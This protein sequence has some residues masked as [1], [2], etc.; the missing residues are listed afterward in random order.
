M[1]NLAK[2]RKFL[3]TAKAKNQILLF[4][5]N[6]NNKTHKISVAA[7][8]NGTSFKDTEKQLMFAPIV[9]NGGFED[10]SG[11]RL[12]DFGKQHVFALTKKT[13]ELSL[14]LSKDG[15]KIE[16]PV[17]LKNIKGRGM[18][19]PDFLYRDQYVL[20]FNDNGIKVAFSKDLNKWDVK[21][22]P[23]VSQTEGKKEMDINGIINTEEGI[24]LILTVKTMVNKLP[25]YS[26]AAAMF[27]TKNPEKII[28]KIDRFW[29]EPMQW[30]D[31]DIKP[32]GIAYTDIDMI[33]YWYVGKLGL[34]AVNHP[35]FQKEPK[36]TKEQKRISLSILKKHEKN[37]IIKPREDY[38]WESK[39]VFNPAALHANG[40]T[41]LVYRA[42]G[43][44]YISVLGYASSTDG[45]NID[46][47]ADEPVYIP[48][49]PFEGAM[50][51]L[52]TSS[53]YISGLG[54]GG[55][56]DPRLTLI[57]DKVYMTY[58]AFNGWSP[59]RVAMTSIKSKD[60]FDKN[61]AWEKP[62]LISKP[63]VVD[64]NA[65]ILPEK[66]NGKYVIF[67]RVFP[68]ILIDFV[69]DLNFDGTKF[70]K[71]EHV[72][73]PRKNFWD[74]RK[75]GVGPTPLRT[76]L[77]WLVIYHA[78]DNKDDSKYK[79]GAM[80]LDINDPTKVLYRSNSPILEPSEWY[81]NQGHK[82]GVAYP[83]GATIVN[84]NLNVYYGG[85]D[86]V[87][88]VANAKI[89][90]FLDELKKDEPIKLDPVTIS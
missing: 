26:L 52:P 64:K 81:E 43:D 51:N 59:P 30:M 16:K 19:V 71:G 65:A 13:G 87:I 22:F 54:Y 84:D 1:P 85:A 15:T 10:L 27:D 40:K 45:V 49:E 6:P 86:T 4:Y 5:T 7:S 58:V 17:V 63:G 66:I 68:D 41:H 74:S 67:H 37:P 50:Q 2:P 70:L 29:S 72:I 12:S 89:G 3:G 73:T 24:L 53:K 32:L 42:V 69:D 88:C 21:K 14:A 48:R 39:A 61:W 38:F 57:D 33:S 90:R 20:Y 79:M 36:K 23:V 34:L 18:I 31:E 56:E 76:D 82:A 47:R 62:V 11:L 35:I 46:E 25:I 28:W 9:K 44:E 60:F 80:I 78:V 8:A 83:C 75:I 55:C 77:G